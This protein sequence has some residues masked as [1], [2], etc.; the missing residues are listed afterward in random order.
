MAPQTKVFI[1]ERMHRQEALRLL[2][3]HLEAYVAELSKSD[4]AYFVVE[5]HWLA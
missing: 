4:A 5:E 3:C 2:R 1:D